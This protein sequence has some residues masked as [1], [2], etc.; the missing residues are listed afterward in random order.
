[1]NLYTRY[2]ALS[3]IYQGGLTNHLPM[4]IV[5]LEKWNVD[6]NDITSLL[7]K[8]YKDKG[9]YNLANTTLPITEF[10]ERYIHLT[11]YYLHE[12]RIENVTEV[13]TTFLSKHKDCLPSSLFHGMIRLYYSLETDFEL[14]IAQALAHFDLVAS[15]YK[16]DGKVVDKRQIPYY[17]DKAREDY[18]KLGIT[19]KGESTSEKYLELASNESV[20][21]LIVTTNVEIEDKDFILDLLLTRYLETNNFYI[22]HLITGFHALLRLEKYNYNFHY[23]MKQFLMSIQIF[24]LLNP[25]EKII[26]HPKL[27]SKEELF[28]Q[29]F[30]LTDAHDIKLFNSVLDLM[31]DFS[32][33]KLLVIANRV[34]INALTNTKNHFDIV[35]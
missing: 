18:I 26:N 16:I 3:P 8:Y 24:L 5:I 29:R 12:F 33:E 9:I 34:L 23:M 28:E 4:M 6:K 14:Q 13:V 17:I 20:R 22:L 11:S 21:K 27:L 15:D 10:E 1:M 19:L 2:E 32:N 35:E 30:Y 25:N 7:D 31:N